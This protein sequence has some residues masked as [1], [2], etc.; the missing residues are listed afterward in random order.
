[1]TDEVRITNEKT[2]G[3]KGQKLER[4]DLLPAG[5][6]REIARHYGVGAEKYEDRNW[7]RGYDWSLSFGALQRHLWAFWSGEDIDEETGSKHLAAAAF[8]VMAL[9][10]FMD[11]HP[12]LD[13]R[14]KTAP[15]EFSP[16]EIHD[17]LEGRAT[18]RDFD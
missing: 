5:P 3:Q 14:P 17:L 1:M 9:M 18:A 15:R 11:Q 10:Q 7:E 12:E 13:D 16:E 6:L 8:H 4:F 2:G